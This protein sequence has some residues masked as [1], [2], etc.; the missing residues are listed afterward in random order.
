MR[1]EI[2]RLREELQLVQAQ[3][4]PGHA[5]IGGYEGGYGGGAPP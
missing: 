4:H 3:D 1:S 5:P 2:D